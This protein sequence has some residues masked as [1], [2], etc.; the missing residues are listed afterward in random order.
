MTN[1]LFA[2][3]SWYFRNALVCA[4]YKNVQKGIDYTPVYLERFFRNLL[5]GEHW[6]L[7]NR[8]LHINPS[9]KWR[10]QPNIVAGRTSTGQAEDNGIHT[11]NQEI[12]R[13]VAAVGSDQMSVTAMMDKLQLKGRD[14][15]LKLYLMPAMKEGF[16][17]LLYPDKPRHPRQKY[18]LTVKGLALLSSLTE[19]AH[20]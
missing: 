9:A 14:N 1:N 8:Y 11:E 2:D 15:F 20:V 19:D 5:F 3:Y 7:R 16:V 18:L 4:N 10:I 12:K 6:E 13:L 17:A